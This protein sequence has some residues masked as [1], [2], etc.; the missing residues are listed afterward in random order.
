MAKKAARILRRTEMKTEGILAEDQCGHRRRKGT[1]D[2][3]GMVRISQRTLEIDE[4]LCA[5]FTDWQR[6]LSVKTVPN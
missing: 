4:E 2:T 3:T 5:C 1:R 6:N